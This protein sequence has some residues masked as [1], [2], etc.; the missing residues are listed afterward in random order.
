MGILK[1]IL[2]FCLVLPIASALVNYGSRAESQ[3]IGTFIIAHEDDLNNINFLGIE[4]PRRAYPNIGRGFP[5]IRT[6]TITYIE[7][8]GNCCWE[9]YPSP[10]FRGEK[11]VIFPGGDA[12]YPDFQP[13]SVKK[14]ECTY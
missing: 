5:A 8:Q 11:Q 1:K 4:G 7:V 14:V 6:H 3:C 13:V 10:M 2:S 9:I 12:T